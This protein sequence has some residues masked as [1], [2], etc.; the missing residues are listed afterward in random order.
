MAEFSMRRATRA[1]LHIL[2]VLSISF[3]VACKGTGPLLDQRPDY[4]PKDQ[5]RSTVWVA[6]ALRSDETSFT[7]KGYGSGV[8]IGSGALVTN[9]HVWVR[10]NP[11][12]A[13]EMTRDIE[14][15]TLTG[16]EDSAVLRESDRDTQWWN[17]TLPQEGGLGIATSRKRVLA[18]LGMG[19]LTVR[20]SSIGLH[21]FR[22]GASGQHDVAAHSADWVLLVTD[23][24]PWSPCNVAHLHPPAL[25]P[26]WRVPEG[27]ELF[28]VGFARAFRQD[29]HT[30][31]P[32]HVDPFIKN[33]PYVIRGKA[34]ATQSSNDPLGVQEMA[35][36]TWE[37]GRD[38]GGNSGGGVYIWNTETSRLELVG[39]NES[40]TEM[41]SDWVVFRVIDERMSNYIPIGVILRGVQ[42]AA[43]EMKLQE[44]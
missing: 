19:S 16:D 4:I 43:D 40:G 1:G 29:S 14:R 36:M 33:G 7:H 44:Q 2:A 27:T 39:I 5:V 34:L 20:N 13:R 24:P 9:A 23:E 25:D 26:E 22:L 12:A 6:P 31:N 32:E 18:T 28:Q 30:H 10:G 3:A 42:E 41:G 17:F 38:L 21:K 8:I 15:V 37:T 11:K 35:H